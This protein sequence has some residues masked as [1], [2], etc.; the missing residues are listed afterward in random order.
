MPHS[1][2]YHWPGDSLGEVEGEEAWLY[3]MEGVS[4]VAWESPNVRIAHRY[5]YCKHVSDVTASG[6]DKHVRPSR[7]IQ[8]NEIQGESEGKRRTTAG[9]ARSASPIDGRPAVS[10]RS[11]FKNQDQ[12][13]TTRQTKDVAELRG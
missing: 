7:H 6:P 13:Q 12:S 9:C 2:L 11:R 1:V 4:E 5:R 10:Q 8:T 3:E